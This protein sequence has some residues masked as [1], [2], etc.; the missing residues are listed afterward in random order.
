MAPGSFPVRKSAFMM[1]SRTLF[2]PARLSSMPLL[3]ATCCL[4][5]AATL[6]AQ[7]LSDPRVAEFDPSPDHWTVLDSGRPAVER[8]E[9]GIFILGASAPFWTADM[10][11]LP[12]EADGKIRFNFAAAVTGMP[13]PG[14]NYEA[15]V[16]AVGP[17][18]AAMSDASNPFTFSSSSGCTI[19]LGATSLQVPAAGGDYAVAVSTGPGC[20]W[21]ASTTLSWV[22]LWATSGSASGTVPF[23]VQ[24]N[25]S[26]SS[27]SG[28]IA[29]GGRTVTLLQAAASAPAPRTT[30]TVSWTAPA[31]INQG[32]PLGAAQLNAVASV[33][34][35]FT[36][37]PAAGTVLAAGTHTLTANF[38]PADTTR[39]NAATAYTSITVKAPAYTLTL[40]R[41]TGGTVTGAGLNCGTSSNTC[42]VTMPGPMTI[43]LQATADSGYAL[44]NW[45]G[46][47]T[48]TTLSL[49]VQLNGPITCGAAFA[50]V[51]VP[52]P[53]GPGGPSAPPPGGDG[54]PLG[55][56]YTLTVL[57]PTGGSV[58]SAGVNCGTKSKACSV[59]M[60]GPMTLGVQATADSG[61]VFLGWTGHCSGSNAGYALALEGPRTCGASF[62]PA[63]TTVIEPP[64]SSNP[65]PTTPPPS[66]SLPMGAPYTLTVTRPIGGTV[67]AAGVDCGTKGK[68]CS[69]TMPAALWLGLQATP[70]RGYVFT[71]WTGHCS[72][73]QPS[74][75]LALAGP[76]TC[77]ATFTAAK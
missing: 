66:G 21:A 71:G 52:P 74:F 57:Q 65:P 23:Q 33:P 69:V 24:A 55:A 37:S 70:D 46:G 60:P 61:Y 47:C 53:T 77:S 68:Q 17:D 34:G 7:V 5:F 18:G 10:G 39:Y 58:R 75:S 67:N 30:P 12:P 38:T 49:S 29:I 15:R 44:A 27:R 56:P 42:S 72:G 45:T 32:A 8:Y 19:S 73:T 35:T 20:T 76:R 59:T 63:G 26:S 36:Y 40:S 3:V 43:G 4:A 41:P 11:K 48:G 62:I 13:L 22:T 14:G 64:P 54:L 6:H 9:L 50:A 31:P 28:T 51:P 25:A 2:R 1:P 16:S